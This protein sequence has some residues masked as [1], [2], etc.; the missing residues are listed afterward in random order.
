MYVN[1]QI[2]TFVKI[3]YM[4]WQINHYIF[5]DEK[6]TLLSEDGSSQ[7]EPMMVELLVYFCQHPNEIISKD[8]LIEYVWQGRIVSDNAVTRIITKLR[9]VFLDDARKPNFIATFPKKGYK[10]I[11]NVQPLADYKEKQPLIEIH[12]DRSSE[13][14]RKSNHKLLLLAT[15]LLIAVFCSWLLFVQ[16]KPSSELTIDK[17]IKIS[18]SIV[19][20]TDAGNEVQPSISPDGTRI[21]Y[22]SITSDNQINLVIKSLKSHEKVYVQHSNDA[23]VGPASWSPDGKEIVYLV[24]SVNTCQYYT[25]A[26]NGLQLEEPELIYTC[27]KGSYGGMSY[28]H[29]KNTVV[30]SENNG[31]GTPY[32]LFELNLK[33]KIKTRLNQP[34]VNL[35]GNSQF[36]LHPTENKLL[37]SSPDEKQWVGFYSLDLDSEKLNLLFKQNAYICCGIWSH[38]GDR[39]VLMDGFPSY[40]LASYDLSGKEKEI[41][42]SASEQIVRPYRH[43]N[44]KDYLY[45]AGR[46]NKDIKLVD[47]ING[48]SKT[49]ANAS[50]SDRLPAFSPNGKAVAYISEATGSEQIWLY[51]V[52]TEKRLKL[53]NFDNQNHYF[54]L[55][56]S[57]N[58]QA[59]IALGIN[60]IFYV[61]LSDLKVTKLPLPE[62]ELR[63]VS[64]KTDQQISF[65]M[66][67]QGKW[68]VHIY[69]LMSKISSIESPNWKYVQH[70]S[71]S[72][73]TIWVDQN[74]IVK[75]GPN[76]TIDTNT[77][78]DD[79][80]L[81]THRSLNIKKYGEQW[82]WL[83]LG[84]KNAIKRYSEQTKKIDILA[85]QLPSRFDISK[86][87]LV[88]AY[89]KNRNFDVFSSN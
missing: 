87:S 62:Q 23:D 1:F 7:L 52:V 42:F 35:A 16:E 15:F 67:K 76:G 44:G 51:D 61:N 57:P 86:M 33:T 58:G 60:S 43:S 30:F 83:A 14:I 3:F 66:K 65:S 55:K 72:G 20:T 79:I 27:N 89:T 80:S 78:T 2:L 71:N 68:Q 77:P 5:C 85:D 17:D 8:R 70:A 64:F 75:S 24:T 50:V 22:M 34:S 25:R 11:A 46:H 88:Y 47:L 40:Q 48:N 21:S 9:K 37:I 53:T 32:E 38:Q 69:D 13:I 31:A 28:T 39:I 59:L 26:V 29:D 73:N 45:V 81:I 12:A 49:V 18:G 54:D 36:D 84:Q 82:F 19:L 74:N 4:R 6:Q 63:A 41:I 56:F 10:F